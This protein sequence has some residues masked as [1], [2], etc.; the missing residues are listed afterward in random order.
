MRANRLAVLLSRLLLVVLLPVA[1]L[2]SGPRWV[3]GPPYF[4]PTG[5]AISWYT[6][7]PQYFTDAGDLSPWVNHAAADALVANAAAVWNTPNVSLVLAQGGSLAEHVSA[8]TIAVTASGLVFPSD[9]QAA[10]YQNKQIAVIYDTDGSV[11]DLMLGAGASDPSGCLQNGVTESVDSFSQSSQI[12]HAV[13]VLNGRC[14]GPAAAQQLQMQYQLMRAF[15]RVLGLA[16]SQANDNV[17]THSTVP[18]QDQALNWPIMHPIDIVCGAYT[19]QCLPEPFVLRPDDLASLALLYP[20]AQGQAPAGKQDT[21]ANASSLDGYVLFPNGQGMEGVNVTVRRHKMFS[22]YIEPWDAASAV[23]GYSF[24][25]QNSTILTSQDGTPLESMGRTDASLEGYWFVA[26]VQIPTS[27][28]W[29]TLVVSTEPVNPLYTGPYAISPL[30]A[31]AVAPSG[32][33]ATAESDIAGRYYNFNRET[34]APAGASSQCG[35]GTDGAAGTPAPMATTG[36]WTGLLCGYGHAAW[37][38]LSV[39]GGRS[40]TV[41]TTALDEQGNVTERKAMPVIGV[42]QSGAEPGS[43]PTVASAPAAFNSIAAGVTT[44]TVSSP[45]AS[46][47]QLATADQRGAG[48]PDFAYGERVLYADT[49]LP[50]DVPATGGTVTITGLGF[51]PGMQVLVRG[52]AATVTSV[53][54]NTITATVPSLLGLGLTHPVVADVTVSDPATGGLSV[55]T[56]ALGYASTAERLQVLSVPSGNVNVGS[57]ATTAFSAQVVGSDGVTP[58]AGESVTFAVMSGAATLTACG[59]PACT[60]LTDA[61]G[62]ASTPVTPTVAGPVTLSVATPSVSLSPFR[63]TAV[64]LP[65]VLHLVSAPAGVLTTGSAAAVTFAVRLLSGDGST[66]RAGQAI[67]FTASGAASSFGPCG[68]AS[69]TVLTDATGTAQSVVTINAA[70]TSVLTATATA[71]SVSTTV[72]AA[73]ATI[74]LVSTPAS[75]VTVGLAAS[76]SFAVKVVGGDGVTPIPGEAIAF[77][78]QGGGIHFSPCGTAVCTVVSDVHGMAGVSVTPTLAGPVTLSAASREGSVSTTIAAAPPTLRLISAPGGQ[79]PVDTQSATAFRVEAVQADGTSPLAGAAVSVAVMAGAGQVS[80]CPGTLCT[81]VT[82]GLGMISALLTPTTTGTFTVTA[83]IGA[84]AQ[85]A[86]VLGIAAHR[87]LTATRPVVYV[88]EGTPF[89]WASQVALTDDSGSTDGVRVAWSGTSGL[90]FAGQSSPAV[91]GS[92]MMAVTTGAL[93]AGVTAGGSACAWGNVCA[94]ISAI[95]VS[96]AEYRAV[97]TDG[98]SQAVSVGAAFVPVRIQVL[99]AAGTP[100]AGVPVFLRETVSVW[101]EAC[102]VHGRCGAASVLS[103]SERTVSTDVNGYASVPVDGDPNTS[104]TIAVAVS[105][106][107]QSAASTTLERHP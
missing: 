37:T 107:T 41:E 58:V 40:F 22:D 64:A 93:G 28:A 80:G 16:W 98:A 30:V 57:P 105:A 11:T 99:N 81:L 90:V 19:Y 32:T 29:E 71:G 3:S 75:L 7:S 15:G 44:L 12:L 39:R 45:A 54:A 95:G 83:S 42:W 24:R 26:A 36:W 97:I 63:F 77:M 87:T 76:S 70:G 31:G 84:S 100:V 18:T 21:L 48:R 47:L 66:P 82:D 25:G 101:E 88:A 6:T 34:L 14:T 55:M 94:A 2:A 52:V 68:L 103:T 73:P 79:A 91:S 27:D 10:N 69:C 62:F 51:R 104:S 85:S 35:T 92:A 13:L 43:A 4:V 65:D 102:A 8:A 33:T 56:S 1:A 53:T 23:S 59:G 38:S 72:Q 61:H 106:G 50:A 46:T 74:Q 17:F 9:V 20:I 78:S 5:Y 60:A 86:S 89:S 49:I 96:A 67:T